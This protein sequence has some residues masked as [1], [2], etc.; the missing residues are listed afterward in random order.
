MNENVVIVTT[1]TIAINVCEV[2][3]KIRN[4][5]LKRKNSEDELI[6]EDKKKEENEEAIIAYIKDLDKNDNECELFS[7]ISELEDKKYNQFIYCRI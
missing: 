3:K 6:A 2:I 1:K 4:I 7:F 5:I